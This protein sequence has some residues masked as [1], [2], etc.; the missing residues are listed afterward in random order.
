MSVHAKL[1]ASDGPVEPGLEAVLEVAV[2]NGGATVDQFGCEVLGPASAWTT[3]E[4][5]SL[6]LFPGAEGRFLLRA[7]LRGTRASPPAPY[8]SGPGSGR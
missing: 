2:V 1:S 5:S 8:R 4:P 6:T 7:R 3:V